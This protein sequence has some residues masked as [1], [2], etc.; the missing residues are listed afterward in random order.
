MLTRCAAFV[1]LVAA[2]VR[3]ETGRDAWLRYAPVERA[4]ATPNVVVALDSSPVVQNAQREIARGLRETR[5]ETSIPAEN[6][7]VLGTESEVHKSFPEW[8]IDKTLAEDGFHIATIQRGDLRYTIIAAQNDRGVLYGAFHL[9]RQIALG[10]STD[11]LESPHTPVRWVNQ[12]DN[13]NGSIE[14][15]Y[16]GRS[17]FWENG[18]AR[19]DL[20]RVTEY[21]RL[22]ASVGING[23][24]VNN[25]NADPRILAPELL[26]DL[27]RIADALRPWGVQLAL[28]LD[29]ALVRHAELIEEA[30]VSLE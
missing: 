13:L 10:G 11:A 4:A 27:V 25:V 3:A 1:W 24:A 9:L 5:V 7:I 28:A 30:K 20:S 19:A 22:L 21:G 12:W 23:C 18:H 6:A 14:R 15:G 8:Q 26:P 29:F 2:L 17:I 16:G